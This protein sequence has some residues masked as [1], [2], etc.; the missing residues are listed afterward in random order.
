MIRVVDLGFGRLSKTNLR[1]FLSVG[2]RTGWGCPVCI[3]FENENR[4]HPPSG[5]Q[6]QKTVN[7]M[8]WSS[9]WEG[10]GFY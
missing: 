8:V 4:M 9:G 3:F 6:F 1:I 2:L 10:E 5:S 7:R